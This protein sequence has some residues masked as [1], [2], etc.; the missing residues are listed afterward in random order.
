MP[1][2]SRDLDDHICIVEPNGGDDVVHELGGEFSLQLRVKA[3]GC[4]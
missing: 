3:R 1:D 2:A 4:V